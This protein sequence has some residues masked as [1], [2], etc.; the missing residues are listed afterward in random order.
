MCL[1]VGVK[2]PKFQSLASRHRQAPTHR[3][4][5]AALAHEPGH[6]PVE[7]RAL[8]VERL[9]VKPHVASAGAHG[10]EV[11]RRLG[12]LVGELLDHHAT[13]T[14]QQGHRCSRY[15]RLIDFSSLRF[16][17]HT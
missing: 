17:V 9:S 12:H 6:H 8:V 7:R 3:H 10:T 4:D 16:R 11:L 15:V 2:L 5:V 14:A 1:P 13:S